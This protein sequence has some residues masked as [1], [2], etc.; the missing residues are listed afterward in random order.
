[1]TAFGGDVGIVVAVAVAPDGTVWSVD[2]PRDGA[3]GGVMR[4]TPDGVT[5]RVSTVRDANGVPVAPGGAV[6]V[7]RWQAKRIDGL[8][9]RTGRL[10]P[11]ARG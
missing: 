6:Y 3:G 8:D 4:T 5:N 9:V 11:I 7:N 2:V 1:M 10:E